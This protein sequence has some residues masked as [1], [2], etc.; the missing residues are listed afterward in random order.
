MANSYPQSDLPKVE[1]KEFFENIPICA[2]IV[3]PRGKILNINETAIKKL[4]Q[5]ESEVVGKKLH[6]I[7]PD[8]NKST[9]KEI[10]SELKK[11]GYIHKKEITIN[12]NEKDSR[13]LILSADAVK[14]IDGKIIHYIIMQNDVTDKKKIEIER[15]EH[16][17]LI[18]S[19]KRINEAIQDSE[20]VSD[21]LK[22]VLNETLSI[23][24]VNRAFL[25]FPCDPDAP[26]WSAPMA[27]NTPEYPG[28][29]PGDI[30]P[31]S[32]EA[33][34]VFRDAI[35]LKKPLIFDPVTKRFIP[36]GKEF[37]IKSQTVQVIHPKIG[38]SWLFGIHQCTHPR[39][40]T[41]QDSRIFEEIGYQI[42]NALNAFLIL[43]DLRKSEH[44]FK[45]LIKA[46]PIIIINISHDQ[47]VT[48]FNNAAEELYGK[49]R[50][51]VIGKNYF[52]MFI[53]EEIRETVLKEVEAVLE[54]K[55]TRNY[56]NDVIGKGGKIRRIS[57][58][59][60][61]LV[62]PDGKATGIIAIGQD[63]TEKLKSQQELDSKIKELERINKTMVGREVKMVDLKKEIKTL[64]NQLKECQD[65]T[66]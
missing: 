33:S 49:K 23:L 50:E 13:S 60:D 34:E 65:K 30:V 37:S 63:V 35:E 55:K 16:K 54:G 42:A 4:G 44:K 38:K 41:K 40:F 56:E 43:D 18:N 66:S 8:E 3:S 9:I 6:E 36:M 5:I 64:S 21:M 17:F 46:A 14:N 59:S 48:E 61:R 53:P 12:I 1:L 58:N 52:E 24:K 29:T 62:D 51:E 25:L 2:F 47:K 7:Y 19:I 10:L 22:N 57:W 27:V 26:T 39:I 45:S 31:A 28:L 11:T 32:P 15:S 20:D